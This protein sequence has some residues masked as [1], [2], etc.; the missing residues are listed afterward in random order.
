MPTARPAIASIS[1]NVPS[2]SAPTLPF[3][4]AQAP[5]TFKGYAQRFAE[6][7][8]LQIN[9]IIGKIDITFGL[10]ES[11]FVTVE[12]D[13]ETAQSRADEAHNR[14]DSLSIPST[15]GLASESYVD[16]KETELQSQIDDI[17]SN[18]DASALDSLSELVTAFQE[19][20][21]DLQQSITSALG[22][23]TS[24]LASERTRIDH[25]EQVVANL[26]QSFASGGQ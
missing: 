26:Y 13:V 12:D 5:T 7:L 11:R 24:E 6:A 25:L 14:L 18:T 20:D 4:P 17:R 22:T 1:V 23:H 15:A 21:G 19:A 16:G 9:G 8:L 3:T 10:M 2:A